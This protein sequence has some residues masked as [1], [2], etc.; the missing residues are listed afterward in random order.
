MK[1]MMYL[2]IVFL[3]LLGAAIVAP[4]NMN[5]VG[6]NNGD[7]DTIE[8]GDS[9]ANMEECDTH[10]VFMYVELVAPSFV[11]ALIK[12]ADWSA[13][14]ICVVNGKPYYW[15]NDD[16]Y[17]TFVIYDN[18]KIL[19]EDPTL[20]MEPREQKHD[21]KRYVSVAGKTVLVDFSDAKSLRRLSYLVK[22][23]PSFSTYRKDTCVNFG[24]NV[25]FSVV[26]DYPHDTVQ[27]AGVIKEWVAKRIGITKGDRLS[28]EQIA[29]VAAKSYF[30]SVKDLYGTGNEGCP[31]TVF[32]ILN[33]RAE[34]M[35]SRFVTYQI[36]K[37][38]YEGGIHGFYSEYLVSYDHV[39]R[40]EI[41]FDYLFKPQYKA[42]LLD[43]LVEVEKNSPLYE[44]RHPN[45]MESVCAADDDGLPT[46][47]YNFPQPGLSENGVVF[48]FQPYEICCFAA[49]AIHY[50]ISY[51]KVKP[52]L[53]PRGK[54]CLGL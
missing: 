53:T 29:K 42:Q 21:V 38:N 7:S 4:N 51:E 37:H 19:V 16:Y 46:G 30:A 10:V 2:P 49:G 6:R 25:F 1:K 14:T 13:E 43:L 47:K 31:F 5:Y 45:L 39:H 9:C 12:D 22:R 17:R 50:T 40:Q 41:D 8:E 32:S 15:A 44:I 24:S 33:M 35:T 54:W 28:K 27:H 11:Q 3:M 34:V 23:L 26:A 52:F 20:R 36:Y 18:E 48:S